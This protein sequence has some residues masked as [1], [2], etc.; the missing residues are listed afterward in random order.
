M[1]SSEKSSNGSILNLKLPLNN[2]GSCGTIVILY[3]NSWSPTLDIFYSS[4]FISEVVESTNSKILKRPRVNE[5]F[6]EPVLPIT[7][8]FSLFLIEKFKFLRT[9]G[10]SSLYIFNFKL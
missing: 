3:L 2:I 4:K 10:K 7:P 9:L 6:P 8:I 1:I 5:D